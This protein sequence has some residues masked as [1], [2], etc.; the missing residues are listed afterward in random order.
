[1][2]TA[3]SCGSAAGLARP[4]ERRREEAGNAELRATR[5]RRGRKRGCAGGIERASETRR[6][7]T[8]GGSR[9]QQKECALETE[10]S[11]DA[12]PLV[13]LLR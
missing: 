9:G 6:D 3:A 5:E 4:K 7:E 1:M 12:V 11:R 13:G 10:V 2:V 8:R